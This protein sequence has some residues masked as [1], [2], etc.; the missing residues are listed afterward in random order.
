VGIA[1]CLTGVAALFWTSGYPWFDKAVTPTPHLSVVVLPFKDLSESREHTYFADAVTEN[2]T[3]DLSR[4]SGSFVISRNTAFTFKDKAFNAKQIGRALGVR[5]VLEGSVQRSGKEVRIN[6][7][8]ID[9][10][11]N[12]HLWAERFDR[13]IGDLFALQNEIT[14]RIAIA[15]NVALVRA[16][17]ARPA[18]SSDALD[19]LFRARAAGLGSPSPAKA[20]KV[21]AL[22]EQ[23]LALDPGSAEVRARLAFA[24]SGR[25]LLEMSNNPAADLTRA[26]GLLEPS[27][28]TALGHWVKGQVLRAQRRYADS[29]PEYEAAIALDRNLPAAYVNLAMSKLLTGSLEETI[30]LIERAIRLSPRDPDPGF[31][32]D[33]MGLTHLLQS[34]PDE[35]IVWLEKARSAS[36]AR[37]F[38]HARLAAAYGIKGEV[39]RAAAELAEARRLSGDPATYS[40]IAHIRAGGGRRAMAPKTRALFEATYDTGLRK[41]GM[42]ED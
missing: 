8:L 10:E 19:Y 16:E 30:P 28:E 17:A 3:T 7:Q 5:Y 31:W 29:I 36:P 39:E 24:L 18:A 32:Y 6:A 1:I 12:A 35:A 22:Y 20:A 26:E 41:A 14:S 40:S 38:T 27:P 33:W 34:R 37:P 21:I 42:P 4:L 9:A 2:L 25:V 23:A 11:T 15:L 13:D